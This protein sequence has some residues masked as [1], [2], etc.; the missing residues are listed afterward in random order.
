MVSW[1]KT[2]APSTYTKRIYPDSRSVFDEL[3]DEPD[4][5]KDADYEEL[6]G[7]RTWK[8][9]TCFGLYGYRAMFEKLDLVD[10]LLLQLHE[11]GEREYVGI[12]VVQELH[13]SWFDEHAKAI[14]VTLV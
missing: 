12:G 4:P 8:S 11:D 13:K 7:K 1:L 3:F 6:K 5:A 10:S 9:V 2:I 14:T